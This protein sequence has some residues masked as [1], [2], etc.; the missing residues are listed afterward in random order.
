MKSLA[1]VFIALLLTVTIAFG[2]FNT[3]ANSSPISYVD[4]N[5]VSSS[6]L[7]PQILPNQS[8]EIPMTITYK[9]IV[10][11]AN[12]TQCI[13]RPVGV[14]NKSLE[15]PLGDVGSLRLV[16]ER[17]NSD[18]FS[19]A[20]N[21]RV[22]CG[23]GKEKRN[24]Q[25]STS[26]DT[27]GNKKINVGVINQNGNQPAKSTWDKMTDPSDKSLLN[28]SFGVNAFIRQKDQTSIWLFEVVEK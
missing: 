21:Y 17:F 11:I 7:Q 8:I 16:A 12:K 3:R 4:H 28:H 9:R 13:L 2:S 10:E 23:I 25:F 22:D 20:S 26:L 15:W 18:T 24:L 5:Q 14:Y 27:E 1:K 19:F 6:D